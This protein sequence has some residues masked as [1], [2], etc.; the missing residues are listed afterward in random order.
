MTSRR[1]SAIDDM[2]EA[3]SLTKAN[4][5]QDGPMNGEAVEVTDNPDA[6]R[7]E[8]RVDGEL[9][10]WAYYQRRG[11]RVVFTHTEVDDAYEGRGVGSA[12]AGSALDMVR[13]RDERAVPLCPFIAAFIRRH[14][15]YRD[16]VDEQ[17]LA[18]LEQP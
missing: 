13:S 5:W 6:G 3:D 4:G 12:L 2:R 1:G 15:G 9:A 8:V 16:L 14:A 7:F 18:D 17:L 10:G 11:D